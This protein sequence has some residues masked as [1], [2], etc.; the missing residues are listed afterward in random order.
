MKLERVYAKAVK[1]PDPGLWSN[2][3]RLGNQVFVS[4]LVALDNDRNVVG[5]SDPYEQAYYILSCIKAYLESAGGGINDVA[6]MTIFITN[7]RDRPAVLEAR[8]QFFTG[9]FPCSTLVAVDALIDPRLL[10]EIEA[11]AFIGAGQS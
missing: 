11:V 1:E 4:G 9:D 5:P 3:K 10:I 2:C 7:M 8:Q 6:K